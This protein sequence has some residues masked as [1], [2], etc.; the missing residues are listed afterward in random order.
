MCGLAGIINLRGEP[1]A[2]LGRKLDALDRLIA[3]RG[4]D[5]SG[6]WTDVSGRIGLVHRRLSILDLSS[7]GHQPMLS[8]DGRRV[9][10]HNGEIYNYRELRRDLESNWQ[11]R[12]TSDTEVALAAHARWGRDCV[13][14]FRGMFVTVV[15]DGEE[16]LCLRDRF[17]I[18]PFYYT[19]VGDLLVFASEAKALLP[20]LPA[21]ETE[22]QALAQYL[23]F[24]FSIDGSTLFKGVHQLEPAHM[25]SVRKGEIQIRR[26]WDVRYEVDWEHSEAYFENRLVE[27]TAD[28]INLHLR[29]DAPV[30]AYVSGGID[31]SLVALLARHH[32]GAGMPAFHGKFTDYPGFD[33]SR[34]AETA[35]AAG[36]LDLDQTVITADDFRD[37]I[38]DVVWALD[39]PVAGPGSFCQYMVS[40]RAA[41]RV[42]VVL[43]GQG[44]DEI[45]GGYA[46]YLLAYFEQCIK[47]AIDGSYKDGSYIVTAESIIPNLGVLQEYLPLMRRFFANGLFGPLDERY[48]RLID[49]SG[50]LSEEINWE[51]MDRGAVETSFKALFN[52]ERNVRK[53]SLFDSMTHFDFKSLLPAL[54][55]VEDR[56]SMRHGLESRVPLLDHPLVEFV[57]TVPSS[58][59]FANGDMKHLL[60]RSFRDTLPASLTSRRDKMGFP[61]PL[62]QWAGNELRG[63]ILDIFGAQGARERPYLK[64]AAFDRLVES[65]DISSRKL[66]TLLSLE[67]WQ[68]GFHD[69]AAEYQKLV[70]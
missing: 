9:I 67:I 46:R 55:H 8:E 7:A 25:L 15:W 26:Y 30:G 12:S 6:R 16:L 60:K 48:L 53:Q 35:A 18:K 57:A 14:R 62:N 61:L 4:P 70:S 24:N 33:E 17:G 63:F 32:V 68:Q 43:G 69:R 41:T 45:F 10:V 66:W 13:E 47:A 5:G 22:S 54:L 3:H 64:R 65:G 36:D 19:Q 56:M 52:S 29:S 28:S 31:S 1:I 44:G 42:K 37:N 59:K 49:R 40:R 20:F 34:Y 38:A 11:F 39:Y 50:D 27:L 58:M 2:E 21:I 51:D 23:T